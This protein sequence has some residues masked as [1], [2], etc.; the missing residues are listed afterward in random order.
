MSLRPASGAENCNSTKSFTLVE[1][2]VVF[3]IVA[4]VFVTIAPAGLNF[5]YSHVLDQEAALLTNNLKKAQ[6]QA[7]AGLNNSSFGLRFYEDYYVL[8]QGDS[9]GSRVEAQDI[10]YELS[11]GVGIE[12]V[13]EIVFEKHTGKPTMVYE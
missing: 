2:L 4:I 10:V 9:Y 13:V 6:N 7:A 12:G 11:Y 8:F 5:Y 1:L 3:G